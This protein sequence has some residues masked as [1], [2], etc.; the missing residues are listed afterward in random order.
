MKTTDT[1]QQLAMRFPNAEEGI[2]CAGTSLESRTVKVANKA[3][4]FLGKKEVRL[5]L[6]DSLG[7]ATKLAAK[8]P[9]RYEVGLHGWVKL[10]I[11]DDTPPSLE[12]LARWIAESYRLLALKKP[13]AQPPKQRFPAKSASK[14]PK[15]KYRGR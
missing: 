15:A 1:L 6:G 9:S 12:L 5:K 10:T 13:V 11:S 8:E 3:F 14:K 2:A 4:L 7:E